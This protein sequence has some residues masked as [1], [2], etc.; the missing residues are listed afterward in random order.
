MLWLGKERNLTSCIFIFWFRD[1]LLLFFSLIFL[2]A[3]KAYALNKGMQ[4][5]S[6]NLVLDFLDFFC[7]FNFSQALSLCILSL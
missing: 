3:V 6:G 1:N 4:T 7:T 2:D 5:R